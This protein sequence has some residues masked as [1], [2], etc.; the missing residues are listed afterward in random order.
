MKKNNTLYL[1]ELTNR[2]PKLE[3]VKESINDAYELIE[4]CFR[5]GGKVLLAGNGGSAAD[6]EHFAAELMKGFILKRP[7]KSDLS[8]KLVEVDSELGEVLGNKLQGALPAIPL[9]SQVAL[10]TAFSNDVGSDTVFAQQL[11]GYGQE[12]DIFV[13]IS[14]SGGSLNVIYAAV[15]A[16]AMGLKV[17]SLTGK[18]GGRLSEFADISIKVPE[19]ETYKVQEF[20]L[21]IYHCLSMMLE[22]ELFDE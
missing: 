2:Y 14:T 17:V 3:E 12:G 22:R 8:Q 18:E 4:K 9:V 15:L 16:K 19:T 21:P 20:H 5:N 10:N 1:Q 13:G 11:M 7:I 6:S